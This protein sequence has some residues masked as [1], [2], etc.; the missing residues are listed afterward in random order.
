MLTLLIEA[1]SETARMS[2]FKLVYG[3]DPLSHLNLVLR[4]ADENPSMEA[5]KKVE[6]I[7]KIHEQVT[8][9]IEKFNASYR[10]QAN[11]HEKSVVF[12]LGDLLWIHLRKEHFS[13][14]CKSKLMLGVDGPFEIM[15]RVNDNANKVN[16]LGILVF[17]PHLMW[18]I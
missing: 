3:I 17:Q 13:S 18:Q 14:K 12:Q 7:Q 1:P 10:A 6:E 16:L 2:S 11:K 8:V 5:S 15:E 4:A 9:R